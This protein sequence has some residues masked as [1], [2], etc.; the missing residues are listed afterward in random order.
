MAC[1]LRHRSNRLTSHGCLLALALL[2]GGLL[3]QPSDAKDTPRVQSR[4]QAQ[5]T[6]SS[7][8]RKSAGGNPRVI[9][10]VT[11]SSI[12]TEFRFADE[13]ATAVASTQ[14]T[15]PNGEV[16]LRITPVVSRGGAQAVRDVLT[17]PNADF[18]IVSARVLDQLRESREFGD[19]GTRITYVMPLYVEEVHLIAGFDVRSLADLQGR[20]VSIGK[21]ESTTQVI[22]REVLSSA[23]LK[24]REERLDLRESVAA[25]KA[26]EIAAAFLVSGKPVDGLR[27][28]APGEGLRLV[29]VTL[30]S[31]PP[32]YLPSTLTGDEYPE[33]LGPGERVETLGV[34]NVL[35]AYNWPPKSPRAQ[36]GE[37]F[38]NSLFYRLSTLQKPPRHPKWQEVNLAGTLPGWKRLAAMDT[39]L[40]KSR[41]Q[42]SEQALK[43]EF[44]RFLSEANPQA[45]AADRE[46][47]F[48]RFLRWRDTP[49]ATGSR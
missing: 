25:I 48:R 9:E 14:E 22:A 17:L 20:A 35:F 36:L 47:L 4:V 43:A 34:Q 42:D 41:P 11:D 8:L 37:L 7:T 16:A 19:L 30:P 24:V 33:L 44:D 6:A 3:P 23:G 26:G 49:S 1:S 18:G 2:G 5:T 32:G 13:I 38:L 46:A 39:W 31:P 45:N 40:R 15:G 27:A 10:I 28:L 21:D 12:E 29:P